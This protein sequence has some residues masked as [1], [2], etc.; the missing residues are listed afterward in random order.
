MAKEPEEGGRG[1]AGRPRPLC[2]IMTSGICAHY[3]DYV[4]QLSAFSTAHIRTQASNHKASDLAQIVCRLALQNIPSP[5]LAYF[6]LMKSCSDAAYWKMSSKHCEGVVLTLP[7]LLEDILI[8]LLTYKGK[9]LSK[10][11]V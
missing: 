9:E 1:P 7:V 3:H 10:H 5:G 4:F 8:K 6:L 2:L 11:R